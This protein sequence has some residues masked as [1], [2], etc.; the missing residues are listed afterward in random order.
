MTI[1]D[2]HVLPSKDAHLKD[3]VTEVLD[4][5]PIDPSSNITTQNQLID[6]VGSCC[7]L[8]AHKI[9]QNNST[10]T[11]EIAHLLHGTII[12]DTVNFNQDANR[13]KPLDIQ[14]T[15][16]L[17]KDYS[18][19]PK[20]S[21]IYQELVNARSDTSSLTPFQVLH[22]DM[23]TLKGT[24]IPG[25]PTLITEFIKI[26]DAADAFKK[27]CEKHKVSVIIP[28][29]LRVENNIVHREIGVFCTE[30]CRLQN[31]LVE[32]LRGS[33]ELN[34]EEIETDVAGLIVFKQNNVKMSRK[35]VIPIVSKIIERHVKNRN[36]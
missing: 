29:G 6:P 10:M 8:I 3:Y 27:F 34:V 13:F 28:M 30:P 22:R 31:D 4:H 33:S 20:R 19:T 7:T 17:E 1:V 11:P 26:S 35:H 14:I 23:K 9:L 2:H 15:E 25:L 21:E 12:L 24:P 36:E 18:V 16:R 32:V 5:R